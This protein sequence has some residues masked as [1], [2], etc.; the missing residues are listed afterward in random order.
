M[1]FRGAGAKDCVPFKKTKKVRV[2]SISRNDGR[3]G[4]VE[5]DLQRCIFAWKNNIKEISEIKT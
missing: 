5:E 3:Y 1:L 2:C 4:T